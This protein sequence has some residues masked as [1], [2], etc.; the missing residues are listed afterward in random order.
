M[1]HSEPRTLFSVGYEGRT[2]ETLLSMLAEAKVSILVD[3]RL[4]ARSRKPGLSK[5]RIADSLAATGIDYAHLPVLG[6]PRAN[7][8]G[9]RRLDPSSQRLYQ[10]VL[11]SVGGQIALDE[12]RALLADR[13]VALLCYELDPATC[14]RQLVSAALL[15]FDPSLRLIEL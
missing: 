10:T 2:S 13:G 12:L 8:E 4:A 14:H 9:I 7:R 6:N 3:V 1:G 11:E 5:R 15:R